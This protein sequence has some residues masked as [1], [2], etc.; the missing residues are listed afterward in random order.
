MKKLF[1]LFGRI[2]TIITSIAY[3]GASFEGFS[4]LRENNFPKASAHLLL[5]ILL[6]LM[7]VD[8]EKKL[9]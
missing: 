6:F 3:C 5:A 8:S 1:Y 7:T 4:A 2:S 9:K